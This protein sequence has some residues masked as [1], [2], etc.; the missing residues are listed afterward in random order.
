VATIGVYGATFDR[1]L[2]ALRA[3]EFGLPVVNIKP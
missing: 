1:F 2:D 3:A